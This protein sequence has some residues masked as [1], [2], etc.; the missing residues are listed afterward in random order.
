MKNRQIDKNSTKQIR[1]DAGLHQELK[2]YASKS[3][4]TIKALLEDYL[5]DLLALDKSD[6]Y[7]PK[8][9]SRTSL[10]IADATRTEAEQKQL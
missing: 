7:L 3:G 4:M 5:S 9:K 2:V 10:K 1:I 6:I 8:W